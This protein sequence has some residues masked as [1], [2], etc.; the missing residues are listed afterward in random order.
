VAAVLIGL[1]M[2]G[3]VVSAHS[4]EASPAQAVALLNRIGFGPSP[5]DLR[6]VEQIGADAY[7]DEQLQPERVALPQDLSQ[8][9]SSLD[10]LQ[11]HPAQLIEEFRAAQS[12]AKQAAARSGQTGQN[13]EAAASATEPR[14]LF[15]RRLTEQAAQARFEQAVDS[16]R[17]LQE[18]MVDFW[19][20]HFNV[21][22][23]KGLDRVL[24]GNY[25]REAIRPHA[26]GRFRDLLGA[27]AHHPA[28][29]FYL[30]NW[31]SVAPGYQPPRHGKP[32]AMPGGIQA[33]V[34]GLN[35]NYA[36]ELMELHTLGVDGGYTQKDVTEL[37]R[38]FTGWTFRPRQARAEDGEV[39]Y[40]D[41]RRH[42]PGDK[43]WLG[44]HVGARGQAQGQAEGEWALDILATQP[45][46]A[47]HIGFK[48]AQRFV[49]DQPPAALVERL[50]KRFLDTDG[51]IRAVLT[52][53][54]A[55]DE[56]RDPARHGGKFKTP[57]QFVLSALRAAQ[58][59]VF[60]V[61]PVLGA[62]QQQGMPLYGCPTPD[63]YKNTE[64]AWLNPDAITR[65]IAFAT[66]LASGHLPL[67]RHTDAAGPPR[68]EDRTPPLQ[69]ATLMDT[70][71]DTLTAATRATVVQAAPD[72]QAAL[73][74]G[75]PDFMRY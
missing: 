31:L 49:Q 5:A 61:R 26:L 2:A 65:R 63:G 68:P 21:F 46:T 29:L 75:S 3:S 11:L 9:L 64:Q 20:N 18:V 23:G 16:P 42:D 70:L 1:A 66:A 36:R 56:F 33:K 10:T 6:R 37:A 8:E 13:N 15:V 4:A 69:A 51:D 71:G 7:I 24:I 58:V 38:M 44:R 45:A 28:M 22:E 72:L 39:F 57:Y 55:S 48:L 25:E 60:N 67:A 35:E 53:L 14:R 40:F 19:F 47:R 41:A 54:F 30:D 12:E 43:D 62:L 74:L 32:G 27:T 34:S 59:P 17:Q 52:T 50:A 73:V